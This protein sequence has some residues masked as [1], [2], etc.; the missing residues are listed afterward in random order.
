MLGKRCDDEKVDQEKYVFVSTVHDLMAV[1][2][3]VVYWFVAVARHVA[4]GKWITGKKC[5]VSL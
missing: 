2:G 1:D 4:L 5:R 3:A